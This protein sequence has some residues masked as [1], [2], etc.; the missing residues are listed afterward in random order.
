MTNELLA[1]SILALGLT[2]AM[3]VTK[4]MMLAFPAAMFWGI[5]S[6]YAY[7]SSVTD[8]DTP[9]LLGFAS[10]GMVM[11]CVLAMFALRKR[12]LDA[13]KGD[14]EGEGKDEGEEDEERPERSPD[15]DNENGSSRQSKRSHTPRPKSRRPRAYTNWG[16]FK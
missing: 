15:S 1:Y 13:K 9:M 4:E 10:G 6:G 14:Y 11:F 3:F 8:W 7:T 2:I 12:D 16:E 5:L